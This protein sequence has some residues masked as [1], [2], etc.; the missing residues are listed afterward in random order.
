MLL[1]LS[2]KTQAQCNKRN[3]WEESQF[4]EPK[5]HPKFVYAGGTVIAFLR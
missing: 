2:E 1:D 4:A 5:F 3:L